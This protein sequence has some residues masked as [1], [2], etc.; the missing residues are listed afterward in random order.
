LKALFHKIDVPLT[1]YANNQQVA[2]LKA[3]SNLG[4][5]CKYSQ[6]LLMMGENIARNV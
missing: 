2:L 6:V 3:G 4:E 1:N 5:H